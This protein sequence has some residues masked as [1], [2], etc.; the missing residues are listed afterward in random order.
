MASDPTRMPRYAN[1]TVRPIQSTILLCVSRLF[2]KYGAS[3]RH[4]KNCN[5]DALASKQGWTAVLFYFVDMEKYESER[6]V[7]NVVFT[8]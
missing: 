3:Q 7:S 6:W 1:G 8:A 2:Q 4:W 5:R